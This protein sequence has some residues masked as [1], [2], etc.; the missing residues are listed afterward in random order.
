MHPLDRVEM[1]LRILS[2]GPQTKYQLYRSI[3]RCAYGSLER[4]LKECV[5]RNLTTIREEVR[6][7]NK[8]K[9]YEIT[10]RGLK[11]LQDLSP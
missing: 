6:F 5:R 11:F 2:Q 7:G 1:V 3:S 10:E 9:V 8:R 4:A